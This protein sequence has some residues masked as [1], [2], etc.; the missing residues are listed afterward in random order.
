MICPASAEEL[1]TA[2][3]PFAEKE[4]ISAVWQAY[5]DEKHN[6]AMRVELNNKFILNVLTSKMWRLEAACVYQG[7]LMDDFK[8]LSNDGS[9]NAVFFLENELQPTVDIGRTKISALPLKAIV[10]IC[11]IACHPN[12]NF[13]IKFNFELLKNISGLNLHEWRCISN[14]DL[15]RWVL[16]TQNKRILKIQEFLQTPIKF[17]DKL[18]VCIL[19]TSAAAD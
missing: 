17:I 12:L 13:V 16:K 10:A 5:V 8:L 15:G 11:S 18:S 7:I 2:W 4:D 19:Y 14:S 1:G 3:L 6:V 9:I